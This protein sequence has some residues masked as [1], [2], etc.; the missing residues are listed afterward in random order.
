MKRNVL[1][2]VIGIYLLE[3]LFC[4]AITTDGFEAKKELE[5]IGILPCNM[6]ENE[7]LI[8][9]ND[10]VALIMRTIGVP[11]NIIMESYG[12]T[13]LFND[14]ET[15]EGLREYYSK[16]KFVNGTN[17]VGLATEC[18]QLVLGEYQQTR[19]GQSNKIIH[20]NFTRPVTA[21]EA[22]A[23]MMRCLD[24]SD[25]E[26]SNIEIAY[27]RAEDIG[28]LK[29]ND[30]FYQDPNI[31]IGCDEFFI[32]LQRFL[33]QPRRL[34]YEQ[35]TKDFFCDKTSDVSYMSFLKQMRNK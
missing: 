15:T 11:D 2:I 34:Y 13:E 31:A 24:S 30:S 28:L 3:N 7:N 29:K 20:F 8:T 17:Y 10:C 35:D 32:L 14:F 18:T 12:G 19:Q 27:S 16:C 23:F 6:F 25:V 4:Y 22:I 21:K 5:I 1:F 33:Y 9:R 26:L